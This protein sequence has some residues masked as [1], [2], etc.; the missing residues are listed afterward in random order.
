MVNFK[1]MMWFSKKQATSETSM[2]NFT[3]IGDYEKILQKDKDYAQ[4][5]HDLQYHVFYDQPSHRKKTKPGR[6]KNKSGKQ[7]E[8]Y[9]YFDKDS[10]SNCNSVYNDLL[11]YNEIV[12][13]INKQV[14]STHLQSIRI[15]WVVS[16]I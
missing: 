15:E 3:M 16:T 4:A 7:D 2:V 12:G 8:A 13:F 6:K 14:T 10:P 9:Y 5:L 1:T 11:T